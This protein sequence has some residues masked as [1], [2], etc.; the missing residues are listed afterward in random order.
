MEKLITFADLELH[1]KFVFDYELT[2]NTW[3]VKNEESSLINVLPYV[4]RYV[5]M[6]D[7]EYEYDKILMN[8]TKYRGK[9]KRVHGFAHTGTFVRKV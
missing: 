9:N 1:D 6:G 8:S 4:A 7:N 2:W 3:L 5:K